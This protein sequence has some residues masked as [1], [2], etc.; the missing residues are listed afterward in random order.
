MQENQ[1]TTL[2][3]EAY[4]AA[5]WFL[6][7]L[8]IWTILSNIHTCM[9]AA[10]VSD[11]PTRELMPPKTLN[12][13][14]NNIVVGFRDISDITNS[15]STSESL[16]I[17][18]SVHCIAVVSKTMLFSRYVGRFGQG[19]GEFIR[20]GMVRLT[21]DGSYI[22]WDEGNLRFD[23]FQNNHE[24]VKVVRSPYPRVVDFDVLDNEHIVVIPFTSGL[25]PSFMVYNLASG[26]RIDSMYLDGDMPGSRNASRR[27]LTRAA[28]VRCLDSNRV[29]FLSIHRPLLRIVNIVDREIEN[30][31]LLFSEFGDHLKR[32]ISFNT[33]LGLWEGPTFFLDFEVWRENQLVIPA[34]NSQPSISCSFYIVDVSKNKSEITR[35]LAPWP[36]EL[37]KDFQDVWERS[38]SPLSWRTPFISAF[39]I[40][41]RRFIL[42]EEGLTGSLLVWDLEGH[43]G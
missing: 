37:N 6:S 18:R 41:D 21:R 9:I 15:G 2:A 38:D 40:I 17:D 30:I 8:T 11:V 32:D 4:V 43:R 29:A 22:V 26:T 3:Q 20:P 1:R 42:A 23:Y 25:D 28:Y 27:I 36:I 24:F 5:R 13:Y 16:I 33:K 10:Q 7:T 34:R 14:Y 31:D 35:L 39:A 12:L 19:P